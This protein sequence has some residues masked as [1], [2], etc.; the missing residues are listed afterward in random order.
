MTNLKK[1]P[2]AYY[3]IGFNVIMFFILG[4][5][6][7][8]EYFL[9]Q[10]NSF[11]NP[12]SLVLSNF[13]HGGFIHLAA[14]MFCVYQLRQNFESIY[15]KREQFAIYFLSAI[16]IG[17]ICCIW[18]YLVGSINHAVGYS[19]IV[20]A[21]LGTLFRHFDGKT[22]RNVCLFL[23]AYHVIMIFVLKMPIFWEGHLVG[24]I[25]GIAY[26]YNRVAHESR[27]KENTTLTDQDFDDFFDSSK[28]KKSKK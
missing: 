6:V 24:L 1:Q 8:Q 15:Q 13:M 16:P 4:M 27:K 7:P 18:L 5:F 26:S 20:M 10:A 9:L 11:E 28:N 23:I 22:L 19:G 21:I 25:V 3:V 12:T 14:N 2:M 17:I